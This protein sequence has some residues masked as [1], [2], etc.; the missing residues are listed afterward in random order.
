MKVTM[1]YK[2]FGECFYRFLVEK[3]AFWFFQPSFLHLW[4]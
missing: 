3:C 4:V 1:D 2:N